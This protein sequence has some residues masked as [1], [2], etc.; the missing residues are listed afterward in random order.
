MTSRYILTIDQGTT[1]TRVVVF[2]EQARAVG[3]AQEEFTQH[4][5]KPGWVEHDPEQIWGQVG[6]L[7][8]RA[9]AQAGITGGQVTAIAI[10]NQRETTVLWDRTSGRPVHPA[11]VWQDRRTA[12]FCAAE[13]AAEPMIQQR[14]GLVL[15]PYFSG[16]KLRWLLDNVPTARAHAES[17]RLAFGTIDTFLIWRLTGGG[18]HVTDVSNASR[19]M[20]LNLRTAGWD[21]ELCRFLNVPMAVLPEVRPSSG[22]FGRTRGLDFLPDGIPITGVAGDQQASLFGQ[23]C[24]APGDAKC[25]YGTGAFMLVHTGFEPIMSKTRLLTTIAAT[26]DARPQYALE[27]SVF[28][29]GA[30]IQ[31]LRD[32]LKIIESAPKV[33]DLAAGSNADSHVVFIPALVGLG[34]PHWIPEAQGTI[35]GITRATTA[36]DLAQATLEGLA[37]QVHDLIDAVK[38]DFPGGVRRMRV[39]GGATRS[40]PLMQLQSDVLG[41]PIERVAQS[42]STALGA[43]FLAGL[44]T[45]VWPNTSALTGLTG[46]ER[47]FQPAMP[48]SPRRAMLERWNH[49]VQTVVQHYCEVGR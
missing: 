10:T 43:A 28:I 20:L 23:A 5:P 9:L 15:D 16:T 30:A 27:G 48:E 22:E 13:K 26:T 35:F 1:S 14:S 32:G 8:L 36:A 18:S 7:T 21:D 39:D 33:N 47:T 2:D 45:G 4:Y 44:A 46:V 41:I 49:A 6:P 37:L 34:A 11:I 3:V 19:T 42:E 17:R 24:F 12:D 38:H 29:A 25:T 40:S 31:W